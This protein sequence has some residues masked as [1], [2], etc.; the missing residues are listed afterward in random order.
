VLQDHSLRRVL[1]TQPR[2]FTPEISTR[3]FWSLLCLGKDGLYQGL[4]VL[5]IRIRPIW[6]SRPALTES[7]RSRFRNIVLT[8]NGTQARRLTFAAKFSFGGSPSGLY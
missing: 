7:N 3:S 1:E 6:S 8:L 5:A 2:L 4:D